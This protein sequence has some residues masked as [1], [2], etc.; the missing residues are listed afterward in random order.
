VS[1]QLA[2]QL[3]LLP[4]LLAAHVELT[5][6]ALAVGIAISLPLALLCARFRALAGPLLA[7]AGV[8]QTIPA[9]ALLALMV[10][11][12]GEIGRT[13]A[14]IALVLYSVLPIAR[15]AVTGLADIDPALVEAARG[16]GM[17]E[18]QALLRVRLPLAMPVIVA[19]VRTAAV[20]T[21]GLATLSTPV[22]APSLG[23]FIFSGLQTLN[24]S[25]VLVGCVS[26][27]VLA[28]VL[29]GLVRL[30]EVAAQRGSKRLGLA[31]LA[32]FAVIV[33]W[34]AWRRAEHGGPSHDVVR[35]GAKTFTEQY[36]LAKRIAM[37]L[38]RVGVEVEAVQSLGSSVVFDALVMGDID[39]YVDYTGTI[40]AN[41]MKRSDNPGAAR[42]LVEVTEWLARERGVV[43]LG[44]LGFEDAYAIAMPRS[45]AQRLEVR[46]LE[47]LAPHTPSLTIGGDYEFFA[48]PEWSAVR[49]A[50]GLQF[51]AT[52]SFDPSLMFRA[53]AE[54]EVGVLSAFSSDGRIAAFDL[55]V[56]EDP[57]EALPPYDAIV[58]LSR[59][60]AADPR[61]TAALRP[62]IGAIDDEAMRRANQKVDVEH[63]SVSEA[64]AELATDA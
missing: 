60:A 16:V 54:G 51:A 53:A 8:I 62:L 6:V 48:R 30:L 37:Q 1:E 19:G 21:V 64:A 31:A 44:A 52:R 22:G 32:G 26:A 43:C 42:V 56:L 23:N 41:A 49:D 7:V 4:T 35:I 27:A 14:L 59:R 47:Q 10:P 38:E 20:W 13:P 50:Y 9:L 45:L 57:R 55:V 63:R 33:G 58:L 40:W 29:D 34:L 25:A 12:L 11:L 28:L 3:E 24:S 39:V 15:N 17:S 5:L 46:N 36:V 2:E 61:V 18:T